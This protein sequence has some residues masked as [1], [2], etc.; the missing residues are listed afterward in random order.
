MSRDW[1]R[2]IKETGG[3]DP[4][5]LTGVGSYGL[6]VWRVFVHGDSNIDTDD[7][8]LVA[9]VKDFKAD[10]NSLGSGILVVK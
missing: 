9:Y 4:S 8:V 2:Q 6:N 10:G 7:R 5:K 1:C 3:I